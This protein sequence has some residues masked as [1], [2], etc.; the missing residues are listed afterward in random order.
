MAG[1]DAQKKFSFLLFFWVL[2]PILWWAPSLGALPSTSSDLNGAAGGRFAHFHQQ[3]LLQPPD[4]PSAVTQESVRLDVTGAMLACSE[5]DCSHHRG[6]NLK[7]AYRLSSRLGRDFNVAAQVICQARLGYT[8]SHG[9]HLK[10]ERC[11]SPVT[12][13]LQRHDRVN[14]TLEVEFQFSPYEQVIDAQVGSI[15][16]H[17]EQAEILTNNS[18]Q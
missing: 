14:S 10:S 8:T 9:Y 3:P 12:H 6:C 17:I 11:S 4:K 15:R 13:V 18:L 1:T 16:C 2:L 5:D 7:I